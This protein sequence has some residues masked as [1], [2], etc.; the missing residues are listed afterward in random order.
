[1]KLEVKKT[2][3][4]EIEVEFPFYTKTNAHV[5]KHVNESK[6]ISIFMGYN[7]LTFDY[8]QHGYVLNEWMTAERAT[9]DEFEAAKAEFIRLMN[10]THD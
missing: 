10:E 9:E 5:F 3:I 4:E 7:G 2:V 6:C 1:M 8:S